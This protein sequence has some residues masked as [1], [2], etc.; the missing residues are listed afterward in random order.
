MATL[1]EGRKP[2]LMGILNITPDS[3]SDGGQFFDQALA[4]SQ[5]SS[6][7]QQGADIIDIGGESTR[8]GAAEVSEQEELDRVIPVL[9]QLVSEQ[10]VLISVDTSKT[11]VM[12]AALEAGAVMINDVTALGAPG[13]V[14]VIAD[15][16]VPVCLMHMLGSPRTMQTNPQYS[17]VVEDIIRFLTE[18]VEACL[19]AGVGE[20]N[21]VLDPGFGFGKT[22]RDNYV[23][24]RELPRFAAL[25]FPVLVGMSRKSMI[26]ELLQIPP[27]ERANATA[28]LTALAA[29]RGAAIVRVHDVRESAE[30]LTLAHATVCM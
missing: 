11:K 12:A 27:N 21:I 29:E 20:H 23:L 28:V 24:L 26:G 14:E 10:G 30:A 2:L 1:A 6:M 17:N 18:R 4:T 15:S 25:G 13:A 5:V 7:L 16:G 3:F 8:P 9:Q 22:L 19:K